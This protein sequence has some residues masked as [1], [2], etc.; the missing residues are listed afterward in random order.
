MKQMPTGAFSSG[1]MTISRSRSERIF[2]PSACVQNRA[3]PGRLCVSMTMWWSRTGMRTV[4]A[5]RQI[6]PGQ[7]RTLLP[8]MGRWRARFFCGLLLLGGAAG[9][10]SV[11]V[12][13]GFAA[14]AAAEQGLDRLGGL[15]PGAF[16]LDLGIEAAVC[17][18]GAQA[19]QIAG[20]AGVRGELAGEVQ[21]VDPRPESTV[22]ALGPEG[23]GLDIIVE[24]G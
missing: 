4:C 6:A 7:T 3:S 23:H 19:R 10:G 2:Q 16:Q 24:I 18:Q 14:D 8:Q 1:P 13:H 11:D 9:P 21:R 22:E 15:A 12:Q 20:P 5:A 17:G